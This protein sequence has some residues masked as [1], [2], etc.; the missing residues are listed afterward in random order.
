M[1]EIK[2]KWA[3][4]VFMLNTS[5]QVAQ[6]CTNSLQAMANLEKENKG[7]AELKKELEQN[8]KNK[9]KLEEQLRVYTEIVKHFKELGEE[10]ND[11]LQEIN[12]DHALETEVSP[13]KDGKP[14][15]KKLVLDEK[16]NYCYD[17]EGEKSKSKAIKEFVQT[18]VFV[19][20]LNIAT[21]L[22]NEDKPDFL[23]GFVI[24]EKAKTKPPLRSVTKK[25]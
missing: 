5:S 12:I 18:E 21:T 8:Q 23:Q 6:Q 13:A 25:A 14:A 10:H 20:Q 4:I 22:T 9:P 2:K 16:G 1:A 19:T 7:K 3:D 17:R 11:H 24:F 15:V